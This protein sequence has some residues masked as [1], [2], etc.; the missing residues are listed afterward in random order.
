MKLARLMLA[1]CL[2]LPAPAA[3]QSAAPDTAAVRAIVGRYLHGLKFNDVAA[4]RE[5]FWSEAKLYWVKK[6]GT[7][8]EL[9]QAEWYKGFA[10]NAGK[11]EPGELRIVSMDVT[12]DIAS[13]KVHETYATSIYVDYLN[14]TKVGG[15]WRIVNKVYT[16]Q[17]RTK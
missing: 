9:S 4:L 14:L 8:G 3:A 10:A 17:A 5:A 13:V 15:R 1:I 2:L 6:D 7:Q 12:G 16:A 11:E